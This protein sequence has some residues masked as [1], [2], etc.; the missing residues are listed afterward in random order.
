MKHTVLYRSART[1]DY[2]IVMIKKSQPVPFPGRHDCR[3]TTACTNGTHRNKL[4]SADCRHLI[5]VWNQH[6]GHFLAG[7][8]YSH[9]EFVT[10]MAFKEVYDCEILISEIE[11]RPALCDC[12]MKEYS[13][14]SFSKTDCGE[15]CARQSFLSGANRTAQR[16][17]K[18]VSYVV[19]QYI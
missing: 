18:K 4:V 14:K 13:D 5:S 10:V 6:Q 9:K 19:F 8:W 15:K 17:A 2:L 12:S 7:G 1:G 16:N 11:K 3:W